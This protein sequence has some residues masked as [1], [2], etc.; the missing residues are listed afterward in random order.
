M[1]VR[2]T[3]HEAPTRT[4]RFGARVRI[5]PGVHVG[6]QLVGNLVGHVADVEVG[7]TRTVVRVDD[8]RTGRDACL[9][10]WL[11]AADVTV[12]DEAVA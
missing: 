6:A 1:A 3:I 4:P 10:I 8:E 2:I 7:E 5:N 9:P 12:L 11:P